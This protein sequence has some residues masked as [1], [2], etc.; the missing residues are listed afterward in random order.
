MS[1]TIDVENLK[2]IRKPF[3]VICGVDMENKTAT[4]TVAYDSTDVGMSDTNAVVAVKASAWNPLPLADLSGGG[5]PLDDG[6]VFPVLS[7]TASIEGKY[8]VR[9]NIGGQLEFT[10]TTS[11]SII[12]I[13]C[14]G[15]GTL[16]I[17]GA[18]YSL[19]SQLVVPVRANT[20]ETLLFES[21]DA[22]ARVVVYTIVPGILLQFE[23]DSIVSCVLDLAGN[24]SLKEPSFEVSTI[25]L[26]AYY[27]YDISEII[28]TMPDNT[29]LWYK[30]GYPGD[31]CET[32]H[33]YLSGEATMK[34]HVITLKGTDASSKLESLTMRSN[35][36]HNGYQLYIHYHNVFIDAG[37]NLVAYEEMPQDT[38]SSYHAIFTE[39]S[40]QDL[41]GDMMV[42]CHAAPLYYWPTYVDAGIPRL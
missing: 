35:Y 28:S 18:V 6:V 15:T 27:P 31:Y 12:S 32:R 36:V 7:H 33:F 8:G 20:Q 14:K 13:T 17:N 22:D 24:L 5:F 25:E 10:V 40:A 37:I 42:S 16:T 4:N 29:P 39:Q 11:A 21:S 34:D 41:L 19:N 3:D 26:N 23:N 1:T 9:S 38:S 2:S 30:A